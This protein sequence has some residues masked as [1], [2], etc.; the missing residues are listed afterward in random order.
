MPGR[1]IAAEADVP[2][3]YLSNVLGVLVRNGVL[4]SSPGRTGGFSL[5]K[6]PE[7]IR[8]IDVLSPF[9]SFQDTRCPFGNHECNEEN[10]C[11]AHARWKQVLQAEL[12]FLTTTTIRD[13]AFRANEGNGIQ[14]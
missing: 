13:V 8:L 2:P 12:D 4:A 7:A 3:K 9:E 1:A 5:A 11:L 14:A 6:P 10:P